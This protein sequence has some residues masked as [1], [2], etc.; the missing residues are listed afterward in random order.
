MDERAFGGIYPIRAI[1]LAPKNPELN[2][3]WE[4]KFKRIRDLLSMNIL[5]KDY[6]ER[7]KGRIFNSFKLPNDDI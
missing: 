1:F 5:M 3:R 7:K 2:V 6:V 4:R